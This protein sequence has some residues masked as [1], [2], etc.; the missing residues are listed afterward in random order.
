M[1]RVG[2]NMDIVARFNETTLYQ[3]TNV[4][5]INNFSV[6]RT[7]ENQNETKIEPASLADL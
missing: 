2:L 7:N 5:L 3:A 4:F 1:S 6:I